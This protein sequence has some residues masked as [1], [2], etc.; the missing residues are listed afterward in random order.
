MLGGI[1]PILIQ[2]H[3]KAGEYPMTSTYDV[4]E[5]CRVVEGK[6]LL[7][8][9]FCQHPPLKGVLKYMAEA[10]ICRRGRKGG[11][12]SGNYKYTTLFITQNQTFTTP[13]V[14]NEQYS[15]IAVGGGGGGGDDGG[16]SGF[17]AGGGSGWINI[18]TVMVPNQTQF[19]ITIGR[20]GNI[21]QSGGTTS[22]GAYISANGGRAGT[23]DV[24]GDGGA[25]GGGSR[26][27][28]GSWGGNGYFGGGGGGMY[29]G[30][31]GPYGG[32]GGGYRNWNDDPNQPRGLGGE[33]GGNGGSYALYYDS[34]SE[35]GNNGTN[36]IGFNNT[37]NIDNQNFKGHGRG[38][39]GRQGT[40]INVYRFGMGGAGGGGGY[41]GNGGYTSPYANDIYSIIGS[42]T[43]VN[44]VYTY[45]NDK[46]YHGM[47]IFGPGG[48][49][50]F[51]GNGGNGFAFSGR[52]GSSCGGGGG[53]YGG[54]GGDAANVYGAGGG[55]GYGNGGSN[56][57]QAGLAGG[58]YSNG[59]RGGD[60]VCI[61][62]YYDLGL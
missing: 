28:S 13:N 59:G 36:T 6:V 22:F 18:G 54:C 38:G 3:Y 57:V 8:L 32:G 43:S 52:Y 34:V 31:G 11:E 60:G 23:G 15:I 53:G 35:S 50:G 21:N 26:F 16:T 40:G 10:L 49:G 62:Q 41:G 2:V 1:C 4:R 33:Y 46:N 20:G 19:Q 39:V 14:R 12:D 45:S 51:G 5:N 61:I 58:G 47:M 25:G 27:Y 29:G 48:G 56:G 44:G 7:L 42:G 9:L 30:N 24:G 37:I 17:G 55:G